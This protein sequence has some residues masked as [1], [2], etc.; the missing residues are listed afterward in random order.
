MQRAITTNTYKISV[1]TKKTRKE[2][3]RTQK[4]GGKNEL[5]GN[6]IGRWYISSKKKISKRF[7]FK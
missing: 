7:K 1:M 4:N 2:E 6:S 5:K 3:I